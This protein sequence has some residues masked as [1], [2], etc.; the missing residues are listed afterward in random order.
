LDREVLI[1][2]KDHPGAQQ[3]R[4]LK[5]AKSQW[6]AVE[7][8]TRGDFYYHNRMEKKNTKKK[9]QELRDTNHV[10]TEYKPYRVEYA[11]RPQQYPKQLATIILK[12]NSFQVRGKILETAVNQYEVSFIPPIKSEMVALREKVVLGGSLKNRR[13]NFDILRERFGEFQFDNHALYSMGKTATKDKLKKIVFEKGKLAKDYEV[14]FHCIGDFRLSDP[15]IP[16]QQQEALL[17]IFNRKR[18]QN[19][20]FSR[21]GRGWFK[22]G[23]DRDGKNNN[24]NKGGLKMQEISV[25]SSTNSC[26]DVNIIHGFECSMRILPKHGD[27]QL[28]VF[29]SDLAHKLVERLTLH[30]KIALA[31]QTFGGGQGGNEHFNQTEYRRKVERDCKKRHFLLSYNK[32]NLQICSID[33]D[34]NE[35]SMFSLGTGG[36]I[37]YKEYLQRQYGIKSTRKE[38]CVVLDK[39]GAVFLPQHIRLTITSKQSDAI[40]DEVLN[41]VNPRTDE[42]LHRIENFVQHINMQKG[43]GYK[44]GKKANDDK[45]TDSTLDMDFEIEEE[46]LNTPAIVLT[47]PHIS[48]CGEHGPTPGQP[49]D[50]F[51]YFQTR[52]FLNDV[53]Q[54]RH[55]GIVY[56]DPRHLKA[57]ESFF[58]AYEQYI[59]K[60]HFDRWQ[61]PICPPTPRPINYS[62]SKIDLLSDD[63]SYRD[64]VNAKIIDPQDELLVLILPDGMR[65]SEMKAKFTKL[66]QSR[67]GCNK[68]I[69][70]Q[71]IQ[72]GTCRKL[73][74]CLG[75]FEDI[76]IKFG[77]VPYTID[78]L[79][80]SG[81]KYIDTESCWVWGVDVSH[82]RDKPSVA[83]LSISRKPFEGSLRSMH[84]LSH[85]NPCR[86]EIIAFNNMITLALQGLEQC[87]AAVKANKKHQGQGE[88][89]PNCIFV[90][91]DGVA[92]GQ[93]EEL[94]TKEVVGIQRAI[95][96]FR[97][98]HKLK[99]WKPKL[100]YVLCNKNT[101]DRF[102]LLDQKT[103]LVR[104]LNKPA[105]IYDHVLSDR[106]WDF[107]I[108]PY[109]YKKNADRTK[110]VRYIVLYDDLKLSKK[111]GASL[112]L[113]QFIFA[114]T[115]M[116]AFSL[117]FPL[118]GTAQ[119]APIVYAKHY[120]ESFSQS[121]LS[122]DKSIKSLRVNKNL[123]N[124]P[125]VITEN[126]MTPT[127]IED[128]SKNTD[129]GGL[130]KAM[131]SMKI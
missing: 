95:T 25:I 119:P 54:L 10:K 102:G 28:T 81:D 23:A 38:C 70:I 78:P 44:L 97:N 22:K 42:R 12:T 32:R 26:P 53:R 21:I 8:L 129:D 86:K 56:E 13:K 69:L 27:R 128:K 30:E 105:V 118:G 65:G 34:Q 50:D 93:I 107:I 83:C 60:R 14:T 121:I 76:M 51:K 72:N 88:A 109:H 90:F 96:M 9:P 7:S 37:S 66:V 5:F 39:S 35:S 52:G 63:V 41:F 94:F 125:Q 123:H 45:K 77:N 101:I 16:I 59:K 18:L 130:E 99:K 6:E 131:K 104:S 100:E 29:K 127:T 36:K 11:S 15:T 73:N 48:I 80:P 46:S 62:K 108:F 40:Y 91:R 58:H 2:N 75:T 47:M 116:F 124:R 17:N 126:I 19:S 1:M 112:D 110:G 120:A 43:L 61:G 113:F 55:W 115:Y 71:C 89:L 103:G 64:M 67:E 98:K 3:I 20:G 49:V 74:A 106:L 87:F 117:P 31:K 33:W 57:F 85:L 114:L 92:D 84:F 24:D 122:S 111:C 4:V 68:A 79:L 82:V